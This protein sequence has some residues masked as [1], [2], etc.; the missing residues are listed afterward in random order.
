MDKKNNLND[1]KKVNNEYIASLYEHSNSSNEVISDVRNNPWKTILIYV[2]F[3]FAWILFSDR[4]LSFFIH[5]HETYLTFQTYKGW[6]YVA[7]TAVLLYFLI[8]YENIKIFNLSRVLSDKNQELLTFSEEMVAIEDEL[9]NKITAL[10]QSMYSLEKH[11]KF[12]E[13]IYNNSN[14]LIL[15][16]NKEG[17][18]IDVN[19]FFVELTQHQREEVIGKKFET[20]IHPEEQFSMLSFMKILENHH[21]VQNLENRILTKDGKCLNILWN[22]KLI[23][24]PNSEEMFIASFGI[25]V[26]LDR[27]K[28]KKIT[29]WRTQIN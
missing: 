20:Y 2:I 15:L 17:I 5:D 10:N 27:E 4:I 24:D 12:I 6:F 25:D 9:Q 7:S 23:K 11:K 1:V 22:D 26:T 3:G 18:I 16:W 8:R 21:F 29:G 13:E 19:D 28:E 14:T